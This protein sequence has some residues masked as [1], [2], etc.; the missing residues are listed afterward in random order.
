MIL[1]GCGVK[2]Y[3]QD[4]T[5]SEQPLKRNCLFAKNYRFRKF[6]RAPGEKFAARLSKMQSSFGE[7]HF[8]KNHLLE[9]NFRFI[10]FSVFGANLFGRIVKT[11]FY[12]FKWTFM[13]DNF[14]WIIY[15][16]IVF[17]RT[18]GEN[19]TEGLSKLHFIFPENQFVRKFL[20]EKIFIFMKS[21]RSSVEIFLAGL[22]KLHCLF[23]DEF[24]GRFF[25]WKEPLYL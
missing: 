8:W 4:S 11:P 19:L 10:I 24:C 5:L 1:L 3:W 25:F 15:R 16:V 18:A 6:L 17:L 12:V 20:L 22:S 13:E 23:S 7:E 9:R 14:V 2:T 21:L